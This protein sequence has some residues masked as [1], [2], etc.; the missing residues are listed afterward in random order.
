MRFIYFTLIL[1]AI[2]TLAPTQA[3]DREIMKEFIH[4]TTTNYK[5]TWTGFQ[6]SLHLEETWKLPERCLD[7]DFEESAVDMVYAL[8][9]II[10]KQYPIQDIIKLVS[11]LYK[12]YNIIKTHCQINSDL[13]ELREYCSVA[14]CSI[15]TMTKRS[16][17]HIS[18]IRELAELM[19][20]ETELTP[21]SEFKYGYYFGNIM[22]IV[23]GLTDRTPQ[24]LIKALI[25]N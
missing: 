23:L 3:G 13:E 25:S 15:L 18:R 24:E 9:H 14:D 4:N 10:E 16:Y 1:L 5:N 6:A 12:N 8:V 20:K 7:D 11:E 17:S 21:E 2:M 22:T 19:K